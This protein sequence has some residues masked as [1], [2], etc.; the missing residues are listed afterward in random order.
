MRPPSR[1]SALLRA[2]VVLVAT[3][4][5]HS[6][7]NMSSGWMRNRIGRHYYRTGDYT[8]ARRT[9]E[10]ALMNDP[11]NADYAFNV[12][13]AM[14]RQGDLIGA[15]RMYD[16]ALALNPSHQPTYHALAGLL[17]E[18]GRT[19]EAQELLTAWVSTQPHMPEAHLEMA[20]L[21]QKLG[22]FAGAETSL[23]MALQQN[24]RHPRALAQLGQ[25]YERTGRT[26]DAA[27]LYQRS[28]AYHHY[29]PQVASRLGAISTAGQPS[30]ALQ[31]AQQMPQ[32]DPLVS[33]YPRMA[34][35][36]EAMM[37][38]GVPYTAYSPAWPAMAS[39]AAPVFSPSTGA[40]G[41]GG[42]AI[43]SPD[44]SATVVP[45][46]TMTTGGAAGG[47]IVMTPAGQFAPPSMIGA[48]GLP[49]ATGWQPVVVQSAPPSGAQPTTLIPGGATPMLLAPG[50]PIGVPSGT[51][52]QPV[53]LGVPA[54]VPQGAAVSYPVATSVVPIVPAF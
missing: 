13:A 16:H 12:A 30:P 18:Q 19:A 20:V 37:F 14:Q 47:G 46:G 15:E 9:F 22:D 1:R 29:Q 31:L 5:M 28:L 43:T 17:H 26:A 8:A 35:P 7:C 48:P 24:P 21:Q 34:R 52:T 38:S 23:H 49:P 11:W 50:Q 6:G 3:T 32:H 51:F 2:A 53:E 10:Q 4:L 25:V 36:S 40:I 45:P 33:P 42:F 27:A 39:G 44:T 41:G 54:P